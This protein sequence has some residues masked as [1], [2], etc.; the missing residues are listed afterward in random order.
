MSDAL[1][2]FRGRDLRAQE[3]LQVRQLI[4]QNPGLSRR[5]LSRKL[6]EAWNWVQP[7]GQPRDLVARSLM[8]KLHR[9]GHIHLPPPRPGVVN[10]VIIQR[11][12]APV[13]SC[14]TTPLL[15][16]VASLGPLNIQQVRR[17]PG[18]QLF[19]HLLSRYHYLGYRRPVGEH[20]KYLVWAGTRPIACLAWSSA[21]RQLNLRDQFIG[22]P[23]ERYRHR[24]AL[25]AYNTRYLVLPW[26]RVPHLAS[27]LL[28]RIARRI[29][30]DWQ[31]LYQHPLCLLESFV[32]T[33][34]FRGTC[35][36]AANWICV[37]RSVGRG[38]QSQTH[39]SITSIKELWVYPLGRNF[40]QQLLDQP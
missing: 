33:Q 12:V 6:C 19:G 16:T 25:I 13:E 24:L 21:P 22:A 39:Q 8:L 30:A 18:E 37:G 5:Q 17:A 38:T 28:G 34:R 9:V 40:R 3:I 11:R 23:K 26:V 20:L 29:S 1:L 32:D 15:G 35:Y 4:A 7:N 2:R 10:N 27:H 31:N 36:R 14:D